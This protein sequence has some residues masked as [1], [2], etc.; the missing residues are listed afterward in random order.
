MIKEEYHFSPEELGGMWA[1]LSA[2]P[3]AKWESNWACEY[4]DDIARLVLE[5]RLPDQTL[6]ER[7]E[8]LTRA[9]STQLLYVQTGIEG[10][11][12][13][14]NKIVQIARDVSQRLYDMCRELRSDLHKRRQ[15]LAHIS[16]NVTGTY[17]DC[18]LV[19]KEDLEKY[20]GDCR[21]GNLQD[22]CIKELVN[23]GEHLE[24]LNSKI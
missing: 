24:S 9:V 10:G 15:D 16:M 17:K 8:S 14:G 1:V 4:L 2:D 23:A 21:P 13:Q 7:Y 11:G 3:F 19:F 5:A 6:Q 22:R 20:R 12:I 18:K